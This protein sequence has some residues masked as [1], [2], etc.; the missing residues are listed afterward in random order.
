MIN[1]QIIAAWMGAGT[2]A[3]PYH[4]PAQDVLI[5]GGHAWTHCYD[6]GQPNVPPNPNVCVWQ[7]E[8]LSAAAVT[9]LENEGY[10]VMVI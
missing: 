9:A 4:C 1:I 8:G 10:E 6:L 2:E 3:D 5:A 7:I